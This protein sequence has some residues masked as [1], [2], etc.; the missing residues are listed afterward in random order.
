[1]GFD[2]TNQ[3]LIMSCIRHILEKK[4]EYSETVHRLVIDFKKAS[5]SVRREML[6]NIL[7]AFW[8]PMELVRL[9][10]MCLN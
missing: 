10:K 4:W 9:I 1:V 2:V 8:V 7:I 3:V 6:C 5:D